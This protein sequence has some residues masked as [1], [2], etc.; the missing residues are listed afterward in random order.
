MTMLVQTQEVP[1]PSFIRKVQFSEEKES[2]RG[3]R[4]R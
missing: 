4:D 3:K 1:V 2:R